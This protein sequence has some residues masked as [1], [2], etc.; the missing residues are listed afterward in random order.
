MASESTSTPAHELCP[1]PWG[2]AHRDAARDPTQPQRTL[3]SPL[4]WDGHRVGDWFRPQIRL[5]C[6][7]F[8]VTAI[9]GVS[10]ASPPAL[11]LAPAY[12]SLVREEDF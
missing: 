10:T 11:A 9:P 6:A 7:T 4:P 3:T 8:L 1:D 5:L 2:A 12:R